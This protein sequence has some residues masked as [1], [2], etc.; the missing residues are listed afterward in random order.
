MDCVHRLQTEV[1]QLSSKLRGGMRNL[2]S[3]SEL[4]A[5]LAYDS[6]LSSLASGL[7]GGNAFPVRT[8]LF[9]KVAE[10]NWKVPWHQDTAIAVAS[11]VE[12]PGYAGWSEKNG[13][14]HVHPPAEILENMLSLR[15]HL[16]DCG[17]DNGPLRVI[18]MSHQSGV[19]D[20]TQIKLIRAKQSEVICCAQAGDVL[21]M[22][23]LLL[24]ASS[25]ALSPSHRRVIHIEYAGQSLP[26]GLQWHEQATHA[27][28]LN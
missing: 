21:A 9:D 7:L 27:A 14:P 8:L 19:L 20:S 26:L 17:A 11:R 28:S 16:D 24:H 25:T 13:V 1:S 22:R 12:L 6:P 18:P 10:A 3:Q 15:L 4:I 2:L 5:D 23:P